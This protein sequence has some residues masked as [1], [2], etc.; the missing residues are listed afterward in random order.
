M[1]QTGTLGTIKTLHV[2]VYVPTLD[3][4]WLPGEKTPTPDIC[5]WNLWLGPAS[6]RPYN[7]A[8]V[9]GGWRGFYD[10]DSGARLLDWGA[11]TLYLCQ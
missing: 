4:A 11:H 5:D 7:E 9:Q 3:N 8:Y 2:S 1:A 6:W 10:F